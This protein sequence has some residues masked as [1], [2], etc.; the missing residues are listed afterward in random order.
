MACTFEVFKLFMVIEYIVILLSLHM[1]LHLALIFHLLYR[2]LRFLQQ[3]ESPIHMFPANEIILILRK[4]PLLYY[5]A[6]F[7]MFK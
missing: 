6:N 7:I 5:K 1:L 2:W 4:Y 3:Y